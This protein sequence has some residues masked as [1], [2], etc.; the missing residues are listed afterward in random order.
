[1]WNKHLWIRGSCWEEGLSSNLMLKLGFAKKNPFASFLNYLLKNI[2]VESTFPYA[3]WPCHE[4]PKQHTIGV[5]RWTNAK[6]PHNI[7][8]TL[9]YLM[10]NIMPL[11]HQAIK[12]RGCDYIIENN[13]GLNERTRGHPMMKPMSKLMCVGWEQWRVLS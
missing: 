12:Q 7:G 8:P 5:T 11:V 13:K 1:M 6:L 3:L 10:E 4:G 9:I 2:L